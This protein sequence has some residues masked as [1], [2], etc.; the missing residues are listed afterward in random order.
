MKL[1][2]IMK[3]KVGATFKYKDAPAQVLT[4]NFKDEIVWEFRNGEVY[5]SKSFVMY[6]SLENGEKIVLSSS[7]PYPSALNLPNYN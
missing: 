5:R 4:T 2:D 6:F 3:L 7:H 1:S